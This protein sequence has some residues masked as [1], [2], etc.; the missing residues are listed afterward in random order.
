L[1]NPLVEFRSGPAVLNDVL[2]RRPSLIGDRANAAPEPARLAEAC[3][4]DGEFHVRSA[5][6]LEA[7]AYEIQSI[8]ENT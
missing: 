6:E 2:H 7:I 4:D 8:V 1:P 5:E 3:S